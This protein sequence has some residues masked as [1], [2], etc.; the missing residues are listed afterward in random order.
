MNIGPPEA[1][2]VPLSGGGGEPTEG[3]TS[4]YYGATHNSRPRF[5]GLYVGNLTWWTTDQDVIDAIN[6]FGVTDI[7]EV[8]FFENRNNGQSKGF[9]VVT[10]SYPAS[11]PTV[12][13]KLPKIEIHGQK[14]L[15]TPYTRQNLSLFESQNKASRPQTDNSNFI[16]N[17]DGRP[18]GGMM[19]IRYPYN[20]GGLGNMGL[21]GPR[22]PVI[23]NHNAQNSTYQ[24]MLQRRDERPSMRDNQSASIIRENHASLRENHSSSI[25]R[26]NHSSS[27]SLR[28]NHNSSSSIREN[29]SSSL[30]DNHHSSLRDRDNKS[31]SSVRESKSSTREH[32]SSSS[33]SSRRE[34]DRSHNR[35]R[36]RSR[37]RSREKSRDR[38][39]D[40]ER[41]ERTRD[42]DRDRDRRDRYW[43]KYE[44]R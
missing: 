24:G 44:E 22:P 43:E 13:E 30:R 17:Q 5:P 25:I 10:F 19:G 12:K 32:K 21:A 27:S 15:V 29:H 41:K 23:Y 7:Q 2:V 9:C 31:S 1:S 4:E 3:F 34:R 42:R 33:S 20:Q 11:I 40:K 28:E 16:G 18:G 8:K 35:S 37:S 14:P 26:E 38:D 36:D 6:S 39:R